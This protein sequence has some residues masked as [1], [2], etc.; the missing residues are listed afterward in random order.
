MF[1]KTVVDISVFNTSS[2]NTT[3]ITRWPYNIMYTHGAIWGQYMVLIGGKTPTSVTAQYMGDKK[4]DTFELDPVPELH[5]HGGSCQVGSKFYIAGGMTQTN[6]L[7][8]SSH[9]FEDGQWSEGPNLALPTSGMC[10][11]AVDDFII[12]LGGKTEKHGNKNFQPS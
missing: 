9:I 10:L 7:I 4:S 6:Q 12:T 5:L 8:S 2:S 11:V 3:E 1:D